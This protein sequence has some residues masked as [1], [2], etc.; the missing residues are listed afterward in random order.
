MLAINN[1][2]LQSTYLRT[3]ALLSV[4]K[5]RWEAEHA[6]EHQTH[7]WVT[8]SNRAYKERMDEAARLQQAAELAFNAA[9]SAMLNE[10]AVKTAHWLA[11]RAGERL[12]TALF[13]ALKY[14]SDLR[15]VGEHLEHFKK[16]LHEAQ[17]G[18]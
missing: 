2:E 12:V 18:N 9:A 11:V 5:S 8:E 17:A 15:N 13:M 3:S 1:L 10:D 6:V 14:R 4:L 16:A 7:E